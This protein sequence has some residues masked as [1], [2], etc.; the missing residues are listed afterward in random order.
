MRVIDRG[1]SVSLCMIARNEGHQLADC[2]EPVAKLFDEIIVVDTGS[3]DDTREVARRYTPHVFD[4]AWCDDFS[5]ARNESLRHATSEWVLWLDADD[6]LTA[7]NA[8]KLG[9]LFDGLTNQPAVYLLETL[10]RTQGSNELER[11]LT[12]PRLFRRHP[13]LNWRR[14]VHE[15]LRPWPEALGYEVRFSDVRIDHLGYQES[16]LLHRKRHRNLRLLR[17][18][19]AVN[20]D[21][22][23]T[24]LDLGVAYT[25][26]GH[27]HQARQCFEHFLAT[28]PRYCVERQ[29]VF[30]SLTELAMQDGKLR[31]AVDVT[32]RGLSMFPGDEH[33]AYLQ[34]EALYELRE[35]DMAATVLSRLISSP[36]RPRGYCHGEPV[37]IKRRLA[38]LALGEVLRMQRNYATAEAV[39]RRVTE[40]LPTDPVPWQFLGRVYVD[41]AERSKFEDTID[42]LTACEALNPGGRSNLFAEMLR[43]SWELV[44]GSVIQA[45][46]LLAGIIAQAPEMPLP[47]QLLVQCL[48]RRGASPAE[49]LKANRD[50]LRAQPGNP[51]AVAM[52]QRLEAATQPP[53]S[54][55]LMNR[56]AP[57][58]SAEFTNSVHV[59]ASMPV[60]AASV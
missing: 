50:V 42:R 23:D 27:A 17:M 24:L 33:L 55:P 58:N 43:V 22:P 28:A 19:Y 10:C 6:R 20:P 39:L 32:A 21:D 56:T 31:E 7:E 13:A 44:R 38:P 36:S 15:Q 4:F 60:P 2:L 5:A 49:L 45:E 11:V 1:A 53:S 29:R 51:R 18:E 25:R 12:H 40:D 46:R 26:R 54:S 57:C 9:Q 52:V 41:T 48:E 14:R 3:T 8:T 34:A 47:R 37:D 30:V 35:Y 59:V 16:T